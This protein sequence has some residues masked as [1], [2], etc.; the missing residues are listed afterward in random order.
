[1]GGD[2]TSDRECLPCPPGTFQEVFNS[3]SCK[4]G[5]RVGFTFPD[6][7]SE[8][9]A[10]SDLPTL[11][12]SLKET[13]ARELGVNAQLLTDMN[14]SCHDFKPKLILLHRLLLAAY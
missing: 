9:L 4:E 1:M 12:A 5:Q 13:L 6:D 3:L 7:L 11:E 2:A 14:V 10:S 8:V